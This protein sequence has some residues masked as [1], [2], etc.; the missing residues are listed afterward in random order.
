MEKAN[1]VLV[2]K[3]ISK[4]LLKNYRLISL[5]PISR[6]IFGRLLCNQ[7][8][9]FLFRN[10]FISQNQ[11]VFKPRDSYINQLLAITYEIHKSPDDCLSCKSCISGYLKSI[12]QSL[13]PGSP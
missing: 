10:K 9:E 5:F 11:S 8:L 13:P 2:F 6:K 4:Q 3:K 7:M 12:K 1:A